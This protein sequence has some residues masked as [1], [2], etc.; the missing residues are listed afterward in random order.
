ML[1][2][3]L[4]LCATL[5]LSKTGF[6]Q[7]EKLESINSL[8]GNIADINQIKRINRSLFGRPKKLMLYLVKNLRV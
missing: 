5:A 1:T 7:V 6:S 2:P 8:K 3:L 4:S